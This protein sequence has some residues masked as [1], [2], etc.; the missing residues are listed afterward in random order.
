MQDFVTQGVSG[1]PNDKLDDKLHEER[2]IETHDT[3]EPS[4]THPAPS[5]GIEITAA[6]V[7]VGFT[8]VM[9]YL[10]LNITLRAEARPGQMDARFWPTI[11]ATVG[12]VLALWRLGIAL[13]RP[14]D[15]RDEL[16]AIQQGGYT[17]LL[18]TLALT[19]GYVAVWN[20]GSI[21]LLGYRIQLFPFIT[22][23]LFGILVWVYGGRKWTAVIL[24]PAAMTALI[25]V[26]FGT[27]L[28]IPL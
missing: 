13:L 17:R 3:N 26:L 16:E 7:A 2:H 12:V 8:A 20:L 1:S 18:T 22:A 9:L 15:E 5:R 24:Y 10:S 19:L 27:L 28:R 23:L 14:A 21:S 11:L 25:Y 6:V 4:E